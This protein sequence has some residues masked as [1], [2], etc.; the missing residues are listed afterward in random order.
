MG[1]HTSLYRVSLC[2]SAHQF[3][4]GK[5]VWS[6]HQFV[7]GKSVWSAHQFVQGKSVWFSTPVCTG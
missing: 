5:S 7:Q 1:Q 3:V 4:Q 6:A 2:G